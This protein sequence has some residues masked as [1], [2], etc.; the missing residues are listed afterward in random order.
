[1]N[2]HVRERLVQMASDD[3]ATPEERE[4]AGALLHG[5]DKG[6]L[7]ILTE[8]ETGEPLFTLADEVP[9]ATLPE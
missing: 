5:L 7:K 3:A 6:E 4:L 9:D 1:M 8:V 2:P